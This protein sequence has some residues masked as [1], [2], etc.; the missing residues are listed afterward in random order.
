MSKKK[1]ALE[2]PELR[3]T[4][5]RSQHSP[6]DD[7][8]FKPKGGKAVQTV[9]RVRYE[10]P[11]DVMLHRSLLTDKQY[12]AGNLFRQ[13]YYRS[14]NQNRVTA[15]YGASAGVGGGVDDEVYSREQVRDVLGRL[16]LRQASVLIGVCGHGEFATTWAH[17]LNWKPSKETPVSLLRQALDEAASLWKL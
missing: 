17:K 7:V 16:T 6:V 8:A 5:E 2:P 13:H 12:E 9:R 15:R 4:P 14:V 1:E 11:L 10:H 3:E